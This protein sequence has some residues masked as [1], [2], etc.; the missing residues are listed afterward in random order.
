M[1]LLCA[2]S[3]FAWD[4]AIWSSI[5]T[6]KLHCKVSILELLFNSIRGIHID[7]FV[8]KITLICTTGIRVA[9]P[10][11]G[12][13]IFKAWIPLPFKDLVDMI[14]MLYNDEPCYR[15]QPCAELNFKLKILSS[16]TKSYK[17]ELLLRYVNL[18]LQYTPWNFCCQLARWN[19]RRFCYGELTY[20]TEWEVRKIIRR[21]CLEIS[22]NRI[23]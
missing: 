9:M 14:I 15:L 18:K 6:S 20:P 13:S 12:Y 16:S 22:W 17:F 2:C 4:Y 5:S 10:R 3:G 11:E 1:K 8:K 21:N 7:R 19:H 23:P